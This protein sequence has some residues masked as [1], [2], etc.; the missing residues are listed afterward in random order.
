MLRGSY[1]ESPN[2]ND[3]ESNINAYYKLDGIENATQL[4]YIYL[5][6]S[7]IGDYKGISKLSRLTYLYME[8]NGNTEEADNGEVDKL[9]TGLE[10]ANLSNLQ[11]FGIFGVNQINYHYSNYSYST[12]S[13]SVTNI[14]G[15]N[16]LGE[17]TRKAIRYL[18]LNNNK[19]TDLSF[20]AECS[21][22]ELLRI[23]G[24]QETSLNYIASMSKL[25]HLTV[26]NMKL[27]DIS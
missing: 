7:T 22:V 11:Y 17:E 14:S 10:G 15:F 3:N 1:N 6:N 16:K 9:F 18:Y 4:Q 12:D 19:I 23:E 24:N 21:N 8:R 26:A 5:K 25:V 20:I 27:N 13:S 2:Y